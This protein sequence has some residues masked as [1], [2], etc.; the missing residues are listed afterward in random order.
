MPDIA[1]VNSDGQVIGATP[2]RAITND[3]MFHSVFIILITP[4]R[5]LILSRVGKKLSATAVTM[6]RKGESPAEAAARAV[7]SVSAQAIAL[8]HLGDQFY[9]AP[10]GRKSYMSVFYGQTPAN[11]PQQCIVLSKNDISTR[12]AD[13]TPALQFV[14]R[15]Y[16]H[17]LPV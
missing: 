9:T 13:F 7:Q 14:L 1:L 16:K 11:N 5:Q 3:D 10:D 6:C 8:H 2:A 4:T 15:S 17:L 12:T